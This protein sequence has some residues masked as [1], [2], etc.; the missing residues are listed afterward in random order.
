M[1]NYEFNIQLQKRFPITCMSILCISSILFKKKAQAPSICDFHSETCL[2]VGTGI[3]Y[4][5]DAHKRHH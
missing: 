4:L 5:S 2:Q 1:L 3:Y